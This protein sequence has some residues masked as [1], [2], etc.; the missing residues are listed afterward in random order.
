M[1]PAVVA[2]AHHD[3]LVA[4][5]QHLVIR[6]T[7]RV[8]ARVEGVYRS[9]R[10]ERRVAYGD[11]EQ[12]AAPQDDQVVAMQL[13]DAAL[14]H[15]GVLGVGD[16]GIAAPRDDGLLKVEHHRAQRGENL[17]RSAGTDL[18]GTT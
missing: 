6:C 14:V 17:H 7:L 11:G 9:D 5:D 8:E 15:P 10:T 3:D 13:H 4:V 2:V 1:V 18:E 12:P 16:R